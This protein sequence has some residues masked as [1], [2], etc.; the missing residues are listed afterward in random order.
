MMQATHAPSS[1]PTDHMRLGPRRVPPDARKNFACLTLIVTVASMPV[2]PGSAQAASGETLRRRAAWQASIAAPSHPDSGA[3]VRRVDVGSPAERAGLRAGDRILSLN[4]TALSDADVFWP[5]LRAI[6]GGDSVRA[7]VLRVGTSRQPT[8]ADVR[9]VVDS[10][11]HERIPGATVSY[12]AVRSSRGY[13]V[14]TV[15]TRPADGGTARLPGILFVPWLS[16]D[17]VEKPDPGSDGFAHMMRDVAARSGMVF[18][19]VEKPGLGDSQGP[20]CRFAGLDDE[21]AAYRAAVG[22]LRARP[23]V[24]RSRIFL[25]GGSIGGAL[26]PILAAESPDGIAGVIAVG[27]FT[28][29]WYEHMLDIERRRLTLAGGPPAEVNAAMR[30]LARLY[31][32][33]LLERR[34]PGDVIAANPE[35]RALWDDEPR[36]QYGR[37]AAYFQDV[38]RLDVEGAWAALAGRGVPVL[39]VWGEYDWI[40]GRPEAERAVEIVN[41]IRPGTATLS[42]LPRTSHGLMTFASLAATFAGQSPR[43]D[44]RPGRV[45]VDWLLRTRNQE[46]GSGT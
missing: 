11:P 25:L 31:T 12:D 42:I 30:G 35:L 8:S 21:L 33:Y 45:V 2:E 16:C 29:T 5:A 19:R 18:M 13:L 38:Q 15:V 23:D 46:A 24:D 4:D 1:E 43:Y 28:R 41:A 37:P 34:T 22:A 14:R 44:G 9:F 17:A 40:M 20:D 39:V 26:A 10:V 36:H 32:D 7:R 27:G 6:R 3:L